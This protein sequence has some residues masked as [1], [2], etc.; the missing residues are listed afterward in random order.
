MN[1]TKVLYTSDH[2][3]TMKLRRRILNPMENKSRF[4][5]HS[6]LLSGNFLLKKLEVQ[7]YGKDNTNVIIFD[8]NPIRSLKSFY[9]F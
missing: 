1:N 5:L 6:I 7:S 3:V 9:N 2:S 4:V 8:L